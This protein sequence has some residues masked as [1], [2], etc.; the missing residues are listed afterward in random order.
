VLNN[1]AF[2][3]A[4]AGEK[5]GTDDDPLKMINEA[6]EIMGPNS[7]ILDTRAVVHMAKGQYQDA[8]HDLE[9]SVTDNPTASKYFHKAQAH[10]MANENRAAVEAWEKAEALGLNLDA[11]N[12]MEHELHK[13]LKA[14]IDRI[15]AESVTQADGLR[16]AG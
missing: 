4:L 9:L 8:I 12:I 5:A 11:I 7:D 14:K 10:L 16:R 13:E 6:A 2:L 15:R 3:V 1:L